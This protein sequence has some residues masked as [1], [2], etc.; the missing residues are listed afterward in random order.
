MSSAAPTSQPEY[1]KA[2]HRLRQLARSIISLG[3]VPAQIG[4]NPER[5][6]LDAL[7]RQWAHS[8][9]KGWS[10]L[11]RA[12]TSRS[13]RPRLWLRDVVAS[14]PLSFRDA[15]LGR[16]CARRLAPDNRDNRGALPEAHRRGDRAMKT[17]RRRVRLDYKWNGITDTASS[18]RSMPRRTGA[19]QPY[20]SI[21][22]PRPCRACNPGAR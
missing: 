22:A 13:P 15:G 3:A 14:R 7:D 4:W 18:R 6:R 10:R 11:L 17:D 2:A 8:L 19:E 12:P 5:D 1:L 20:T 21:E 9:V 16:E